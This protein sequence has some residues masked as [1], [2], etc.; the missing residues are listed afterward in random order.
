MSAAQRRLPLSVIPRRTFDSDNSPEKRALKLSSGAAVVFLLFSSLGWGQGGLRGGIGMLN[1]LW[2]VCRGSFCSE[3]GGS[4]VR[5]ELLRW[6]F[7]AAV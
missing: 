1:E 6:A 2:E 7:E 3:Y 4:S 5:R